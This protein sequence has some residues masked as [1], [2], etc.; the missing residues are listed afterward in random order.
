MQ[1]QSLQQCQDI[2]GHAREEIQSVIQLLKKT[3]EEIRDLV[4]GRE[5]GS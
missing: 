5:S 4:D 3:Q 1:L 2:P